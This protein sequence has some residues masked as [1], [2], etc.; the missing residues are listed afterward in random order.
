VIDEQ[1]SLRDQRLSM[2]SDISNGSAEGPNQ[3][4]AG[5]RSSVPTPPDLALQASAKTSPTKMPPHANLLDAIRG[6]SITSLKKVED[7][8]IETRSPRKSDPSKSSREP[9]TLM[10][11]LQARMNR[12][13]QIMSGNANPTKESAAILLEPKL[14][15]PKLPQLSLDEGSDSEM[16]LASS[17]FKLQAVENPSARIRA[18]QEE[19]AA[20]MLFLSPASQ[21]DGKTGSK[22]NSEN[23]V[24]SKLLA[25][26]PES[27]DVSSDEEWDESD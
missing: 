10:E 7:S 4:A 11:E 5:R 8:Q 26:R 20:K 22:F 1:K 16:S 18:S 15:P 19:S 24:L 6:S 21:P 12:R 9:A 2:S 27:E 25:M 14:G 13:F 17:S 23:E 3:Q